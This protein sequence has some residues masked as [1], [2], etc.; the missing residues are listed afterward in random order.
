MKNS[1]ITKFW[2]L[3]TEL[4]EEGKI[5][6]MELLTS[7]KRQEVAKLYWE[8]ARRETSLF[9]KVK[10]LFRK[11]IMSMIKRIWRDERSEV[12]LFAVF[13]R[14]YTEQL[15]LEA[16]QMRRAI[17]SN[18][19]ELSKQYIEEVHQVTVD[20]EYLYAEDN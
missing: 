19:T 11:Y 3:M 16:E 8:A 6:F 12:E 17:L 5:D 7:I 18:I 4:I 13:D 20:K 10:M 1:E 15:E 2:F 14:Q 9:K